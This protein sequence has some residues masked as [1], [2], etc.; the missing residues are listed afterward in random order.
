M[1]DPKTLDKKRKKVNRHEDLIKLVRER[2]SGCQVIEGKI[3]VFYAASWSDYCAFKAQL[4][5]VLHLNVLDQ[6]KEEPASRRYQTIYVHPGF[7]RKKLFQLVFV[8]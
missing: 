3:P 7:R 2:L 8:V 1:P 5:S 6:P 4:T